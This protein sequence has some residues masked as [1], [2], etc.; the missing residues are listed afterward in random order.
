M[1]VTSTRRWGTL[2]FD[3][4]YQ[5]T[6][7]GAHDPSHKVIEGLLKRM[8]DDDDSGKLIVLTTGDKEDDMEEFLD[9]ND[10]LRHRFVRRIEFED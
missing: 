1:P 8:E 10:R 9:S 2:F 4:A 7:T 3:E 6:R 5:L